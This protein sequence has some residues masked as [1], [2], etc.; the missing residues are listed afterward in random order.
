[1]SEE[2]SVKCYNC[3]KDISGGFE[4][5]PHCGVPIRYS[6][7]DDIKKAT[8]LHTEGNVMA[9]RGKYEEAIKLFLQAVELFPEYAIA[10]YNLGLAYIGLKMYPEAIE[11]FSQAIHLKPDFAAA[12]T[13]RGD[14]YAAISELD[15][16]I[17][18]Y[19]KALELYPDY[20]RAYYKRAQAYLSKGEGWRAKED[21]QSYLTYK[22]H[23]VIARRKLE[24]IN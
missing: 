12:Y 3:S 21:L 18:D 9:S 16:A 8:S 17:Q 24:S 5:C 19:S 13:S 4:K 2:I 7:I 10:Y 14:A 22:P 6:R 11:G 23:D 20:A 15:K 1:M